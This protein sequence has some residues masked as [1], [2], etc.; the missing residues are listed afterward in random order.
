MASGAEEALDAQWVQA[1]VRKLRKKLRQI[2]RLER[3]DRE[4]SD[5]ELDKV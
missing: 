1:V 5:E 2:E 3:L 4:L